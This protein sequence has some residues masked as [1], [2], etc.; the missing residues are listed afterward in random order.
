MVV[1]LIEGVVMS[2]VGGA[3]GV[4]HPLQVKSLLLKAFWRK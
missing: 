4:G 2:V 1:L 3:G